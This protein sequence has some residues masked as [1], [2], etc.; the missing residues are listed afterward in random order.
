MHV[1]MIYFLFFAEQWTLRSGSMYISKQISETAAKNIYTQEKAMDSV[2]EN[3]YRTVNF[4]PLT[5]GQIEF[6]FMAHLRQYVNSWM[7]YLN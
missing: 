1:M 3:V 4:I 5:Q 7:N 6:Q 2:E